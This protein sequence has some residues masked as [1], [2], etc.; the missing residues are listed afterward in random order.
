MRGEFTINGERKSYE[1]APDATLLE[2]LRANGHTEVKDGCKEGECGACVVLLAG[3]LVNSC[4]V[5]AA[6]VLGKEILTVTGIGS[7]HNPH[8]IQAAFAE[9]GAVQCGF[10]TP[11]M[12][13]AAYSLLERNPEPSEDEIK[14]ALDGNL[15]RCTGYVK[16]IDAIK[17]ASQRF[18]VKRME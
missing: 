9:T 12:V 7:V 13:L 6:S 8:P 3:K 5:F 4:Q 1:F 16:I 17:L 2:V 14:K 11:G 10:C 18:A 15:C